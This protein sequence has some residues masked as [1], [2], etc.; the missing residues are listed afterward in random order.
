L[1]KVLAVCVSPKKGP[2]EPVE[3]AAALEGLGFRSDIHAG[4]WHRQVSLLAQ[5]SVD[6]VLARGVRAGPG[7]FGE[8]I[9]TLGV[10]LR[11]LR[12]GQRLR[13]GAVLLEVTQIGKECHSPCV[14]ARKAGECV[15][16]TDG[17]F[18]RILSGGDIAPGD[19]ITLEEPFRSTP[20]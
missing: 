9:L 19:V 12:K 6:R 14:I 5:E 2:K 13:V 16:P 1:A 17:I 3:R 4:D 7:D 11:S 20:G 18:T 10:D 15:M 8:N